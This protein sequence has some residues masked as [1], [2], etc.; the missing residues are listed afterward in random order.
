MMQP[1]SPRL[2]P[3]RDPTQL[4]TPH[5]RTH[6]NVYRVV[7]V[8][9]V[10]LRHVAQHLELHQRLVVEALLVADHLPAGCDGWGGVGGVMSGCDGA[11]LV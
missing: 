7:L 8:A 6:L 4:K 5:T 1:V 10:A 9:R 2:G 11:W 3:T